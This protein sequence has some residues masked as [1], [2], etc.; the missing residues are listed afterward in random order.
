MVIEGGGSLVHMWR[1]E[2]EEMGWTAGAT[3]CLPYPYSSAAFATF[4]Y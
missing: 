2:R 1:E 4:H 3:H